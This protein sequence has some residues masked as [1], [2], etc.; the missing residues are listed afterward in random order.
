MDKLPPLKAVQAFEATA[1]HLSFSRA[2]DELC[3]TQSAISHQVRLLE[4]FLGKKLL[5]RRGRTVTLTLEGD[6]FFSVVGD[7]FRRMGSVTD[8]LT[9]KARTTLKVMAQ[10]TFASEWVMPRLHRFTAAHSDIDTRLDTFLMAKSFDA[11]DYDILIGAWPA[12]EGFVSQRI[13]DDRWF[14]VCAPQVFARLDLNDPA[15]LLAFPLYSSEEGSDWTL[16]MQQQGV[17]APAALDIRHF[18]LA[19][20]TLKAATWGQGI[21]LSHGLIAGGMIE[22][23]LLKPLPHF[24]YSLPW[25][26]Y[27]LHHRS[28]SHNAEEIAHF[29]HWILAELAPRPPE[30]AG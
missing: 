30:T 6:T 7:C 24:S 25:G 27:Y 9:G 16:W 17:R 5:T 23:G 8:H 22:A 12:P 4:D 2:A 19:L 11:A 29:I 1:R 15:S 20:L 28:S 3:V 18:N 14:P 10:T 26:Q 21:A 13:R